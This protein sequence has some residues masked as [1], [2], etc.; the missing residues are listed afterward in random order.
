MG[1]PAALRSADARALPPCPPDRRGRDHPRPS[2][3]R[4]VPLAGGPRRSRDP[5][6]GCGRGRALPRLDRPAGPAGTGCGSRLRGAPPG[7]RRTAPRGRGPLA[8][9]CDGCPARTTPSLW[10]EERGER[11]LLID[12][13]ALSEDHTVTLDGWAVSK[14]GERLAYLLSEGG[15]EESALRIMDVATGAVLDGPIDR[16][17]YSPDR[18][19]AGRRRALLRAPAAARL[20]AAGGGAVPPAGLPPPGRHRPGRGRHGLRRGLRS[21]VVFRREHLAR[22]TLG[23]RDG[24]PGDRPAQRLLPGRSG[25]DRPARTARHDWRVVLEGVD[26]Q[27]WPVFG[28]DG[29]IAPRH[30][31]RRASPQTGPHRP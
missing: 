23:E 13:S 27:A 18:L 2:R 25:L 6:L 11:R 28:R 21:D 7:L 9:S 1:A 17:R 19:V 14:E 29:R 24:E 16:T 3:R 12:P 8:S 31:P 15:D 4:P 10:V 22:R 30:R 5:G 26:A 20:G